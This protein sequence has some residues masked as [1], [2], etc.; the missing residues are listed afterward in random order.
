LDERIHEAAQAAVHP[1]VS[2]SE[3]IQTEPELETEASTAT[4]VPAEEP[5]AATDPQQL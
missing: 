4:D 2:E 5:P 1:V 3:S